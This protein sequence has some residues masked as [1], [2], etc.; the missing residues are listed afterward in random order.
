MRSSRV[1]QEAIEA[2]EVGLLG[3]DVEQVTRSTGLDPV[4]PERLTQLRNHVL[5]RR[6]GRA[7]RVLAPELVEQLVRRDHAPCVERQ[8]AQQRAL[9]LPAER[10]RPAV[11]RDLE[12]PEDANVEHTLFVTPV[13]ID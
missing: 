6:P 7:R 8:Q 12:W 1:V 2:A 3:R 10:E 4:V 11:A 13:A 9:L 5:E